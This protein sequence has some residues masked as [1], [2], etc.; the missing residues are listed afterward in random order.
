MEHLKKYLNE[1]QDPAAVQKILEKVSD[2]L[3]TNEV[4][5]Y[6]AVQKKP[7]LNLSPDCISLTNKRIIFC[8]PKTFGFSMDFQDFQWKDVCDCHMKEGIM[9]ATFFMK[10]VRNQVVSLNYL[11]K[12]QARMLYRFA[13][14]REEEMSE[15]RRQRELEN[16]R[17]NAGGSITVN[18]NDQTKPQTSTAIVDDPMASLQKLKTLFDNSLIS[19]DEFDSK[20][21]EILSRL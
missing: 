11:P 14:E 4:I 17:A 21:N 20:K 5:E 9:G 16:A 12:S 6:I 15:Y 1:Q 10:T 3:T 8:H 2:L 19:Q 18:T 13:Q 7:A